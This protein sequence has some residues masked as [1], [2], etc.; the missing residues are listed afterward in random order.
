MKI[1]AP[2]VFYLL[3]RLVKVKSTKWSLQGLYTLGRDAAAGIQQI[4]QHPFNSCL[5]MPFF[6]Y[7]TTHTSIV[8]PR[9]IPRLLFF[10]YLL[11]SLRHLFVSFFSSHHANYS[12]EMF[13]SR[14]ML[15]ERCKCFVERLIFA[16][17]KR[18]QLLRCCCALMSLQFTSVMPISKPSVCCFLAF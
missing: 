15:D 17:L 5:P 14:L 3:R 7:T 6:T 9:V 8:I 13:Q 12:V 1:W 18:Q 2:N 4:F 10:I 11:Y 16:L